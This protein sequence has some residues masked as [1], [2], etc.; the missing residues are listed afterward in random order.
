M[1]IPLMLI[2]WTTGD[3]NRCFTEFDN[4]LDF[5]FLI[6][7]LMSC[8]MGF[9]LMYSTLLCTAFNSALTTTIVGCLK[10]KKNYFILFQKF[11]YFQKIWSDITEYF[12]DL[13]RNVYRRRLY[14]QYYEL[15]W[16]QYFNDRKSRL[17]LLYFCAKGK[18]S[19]L[20]SK[21]GIQII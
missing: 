13:Y 11:E 10:V 14:L 21:L 1:I 19:A 18:T 12:S 16:S 15:H 17:L 3:L 4:W 20:G 2:S 5:G 6:S 9:V 8:L 7:F